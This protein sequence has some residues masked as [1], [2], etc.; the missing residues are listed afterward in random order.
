MN[1]KHIEMTP[2]AG[3]YTKLVVIVDGDRRAIGEIVSKAQTD[4][5]KYEVEV[6]K[7]RSKRSLTANAY[8]WVLV[9]QIA[10][11]LNT[12]KRE[13]HEELIRR[14]GAFKTDGKGGKYI[15]PLE[16]GKD[17]K[18]IAPYTMMI[19]E[20]EVNG[21]P[22]IFY[23]VLKGSSE[24]DNSEFNAL[25]QGCRSEAADLGIQVMTEKEIAELEHFDTSSTLNEEKL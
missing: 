8:Y 9:E 10:K 17:P 5:D 15:F 22:A 7:V 12:S 16:P 23:A 3:G 18:G 4:P 2:S 11:T 25:L 20:K 19:A 21:K 6:K 24:L 1:I 14:Y 13:I